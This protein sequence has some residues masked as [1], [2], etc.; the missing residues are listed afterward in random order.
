MR[1][2]FRP[3]SDFVSSAPYRLLPLRFERLAGGRYV[4]TNDV[5]E[6]VVLQRDDLERLVAR[7]LDPATAVYKALKSRHFLYDDGST[8]ALDL[9]ALKVRSRA[10]RLAEFTGLH[11]FVVTLRCDHSCQYC[12]VS[13]QSVDRG[14]FD[15]SAEHAD[16][17]VDLVFRSPNPNI[18]IE[19]QGGEPLLAFPI[20]RRVVE[21]ARRINETERRNLRFVIASTLHHLDDDMLA[22]CRDGGIDLSTSIDG[23]AGLHDAQRRSPSGDSHRRTVDGITRARRAL[24]DDRVAALMTTTRASLPRVEEIVDEYVRLGFHSVF[25]RALSPYGFAAKSLV[26]RYDADDWLTFY[27][28]GLARV[29]RANASGFSMREEYTT[30]LLQKMFSPLGAGYVDLQSPSGIGI[31]GLVYNY[32]G[33]VYASDEGRMLAEMGDDS[34]RLGHVE[35]SSYEEI[36]T[37]D[38]LLEPITQTI[39]EGMPMCADCGFLPY[40][41][42]DPVF[43]RATQ[44]DAVGHKAFSAFCAK[45]MGM[46]R[47]L[48]TLLETDAGARDVLLGWV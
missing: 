33:A 43:H 8:A 38:A 7:E 11:I 26:K 42:A 22:L 27:R 15:M 45:Q 2:P 34:F 5:G 31:G 13:R 12:Q 3:A 32:D 9:L 36:M 20:I 37:S 44:R 29:L 14:R 39:S 18:K 30:I 46:L 17:A 10:E 41:G 19:F 1:A 21:R 48:I 6:F 4:V 35:T 24:G 47:H 40:C 25:L 16:R 23:P 28:R